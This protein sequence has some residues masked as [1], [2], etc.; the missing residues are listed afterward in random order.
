MYDASSAGVERMH[1]DE[2]QGAARE[3]LVPIFEPHPNIGAKIDR[4]APEELGISAV[5]LSSRATEQHKASKI[6][7]CA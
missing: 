4:E 1:S 5:D 7:N 6:H 3:I 2:S